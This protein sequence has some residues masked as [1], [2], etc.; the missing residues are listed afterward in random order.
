MNVVV[1][2]QVFIKRVHVTTGFTPRPKAY[3][4][5]AD[6]Q[7]AINILDEVGGMYT[8]GVYVHN[9]LPAGVRRAVDTSTRFQPLS[10]TEAIGH[11]A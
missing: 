8:L 6:L 10:L 7:T 1:S 2:P 5:T 9:A 4:T 3:T 11:L